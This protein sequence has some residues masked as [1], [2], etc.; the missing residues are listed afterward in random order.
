LRT[1]FFIGVPYDADDEVIKRAYKKLALEHHPD[2]PNNKGREQEAAAFFHKINLAYEQ[3]N[4]NNSALNV[5]KGAFKA[6]DLQSSLEHFFFTTGHNL[7]S[8]TLSQNS[9]SG[10][11]HYKTPPPT[12]PSV[13]VSQS[14]S[15]KDGQSLQ[16]TLHIGFFESLIG[17]TKVIEYNQNRKC[18]HC[19]GN[20][21]NVTH[22]ECKDCTHG[23][24]FDPKYPNLI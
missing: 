24:V 3:L 23:I 11:F 15:P 6:T 2:R 9:K 22:I 18:D 20:A 19:N 17:C 13:P 8:F 14:K 5:L 7:N 1:Y 21:S 12:P 10:S 16:T 4:N